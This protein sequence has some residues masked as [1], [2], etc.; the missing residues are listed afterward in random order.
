MSIFSSLAA[1]IGG[2]ESE[3]V[4]VNTTSHSTGDSDR[5]YEIGQKVA[6]RGRAHGVDSDRVSLTSWGGI[7]HSKTGGRN[8]EEEDDSLYHE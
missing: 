1:L 4:S 7:A 6:A 5:D 3:E 8:H 2:S